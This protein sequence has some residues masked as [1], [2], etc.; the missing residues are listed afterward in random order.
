MFTL[1]LLLWGCYWLLELTAV[2]KMSLSCF[3]VCLFFCSVR[4]VLLLVAPM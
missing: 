2:V 1:G 4:L 3:S